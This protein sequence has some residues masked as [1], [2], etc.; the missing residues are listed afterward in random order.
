MLGSGVQRNRLVV[1]A[2]QELTGRKGADR[3]LV[4]QGLVLSPRHVIGYLRRRV[5]QVAPS[6]EGSTDRR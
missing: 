2:S 4:T 3:Q 5:D 6:W 1:T